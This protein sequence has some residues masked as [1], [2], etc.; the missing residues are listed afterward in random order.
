VRAESSDSLADTSA[1][2]KSTLPNPGISIQRPRVIR[3][4]ER[5][6][7][8]AAILW[9]TEDLAKMKEYL[10][11]M[12]YRQGSLVNELRQIRVGVQDSERVARGQVNALVDA[13]GGNGQLLR[14]LH[15]EMVGLRRDNAGAME[16]LESALDRM[17]GAYRGIDQVTSM[18]RRQ[19]LDFLGTL[20]REARSQNSESGRV[21]EYR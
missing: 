2:V 4:P 20:I 21:P 14:V 1:P 7:E 13:V 18:E 17:S 19:N 16:R 8:D 15:G 6:R 9:L 10:S 12:T 11:S 5:K 3:S